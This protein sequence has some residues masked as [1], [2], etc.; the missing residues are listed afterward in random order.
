MSMGGRPSPGCILLTLGVALVAGAIAIPF[1]FAKKDP[2]NATA[3]PA[4]V[5]SPLTTSARTAATTP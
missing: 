2:A 1:V 4:A 3:T 5:T